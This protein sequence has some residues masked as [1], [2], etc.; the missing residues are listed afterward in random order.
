MMIKYDKQGMG[1][2]IHIPFCLSKCYYCDFCSLPHRKPQEI[3]EYVS[4]LVREIKLFDKK[5]KRCAKTVYFGGGTPTLLSVEQ[6]KQILDAVNSVFMLCEDT[7]ITAE[8]NPKSADLVKLRG[9]RECG[10]NRL[11]I[12]LQ[13]VHDNELRALGR[14]HTYKDFLATYLDARQ[15][16]FNNISFDLMYGIPEQSIDSFLEGLCRVIELAPEHISS[17]SLILEEETRFYERR[18]LLP[19]PS[20]DE[21]TAMYEKMTDLLEKSGYT[22]YEVSNFARAGYESRHNLIYWNYGDYIGFGS[23]AHS[24]VDRVRSANSR[25]VAAYIRGEDVRKILEYIGETEA[26]NEYVM[27]GMRLTRGVSR[28]EFFDLFGV[29]LFDLFGDRFKKYTDKYVEMDDFGCRFTTEGFFVSNTILSDVLDFP[30][31]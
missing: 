27:L 6:F 29:D 22:K 18:E 8:C 25:D 2:Y 1:V 11:S 12:G 21:V 15:A 31:E 28:A 19:L 30:S 23:S 13:S 14:V 4:R 5:E 17:Y 10:I 24:F 26:Q 7:E 16:G 20:E 3:E 9:M